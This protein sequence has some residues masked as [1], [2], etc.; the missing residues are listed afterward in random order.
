MTLKVFVIQIL[1]ITFASVTPSAEWHQPGRYNKA[2]SSS[3]PM[4]PPSLERNTKDG[5]FDLY[6]NMK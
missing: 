1:F 4:P 6:Q 5:A 2:L 3:I